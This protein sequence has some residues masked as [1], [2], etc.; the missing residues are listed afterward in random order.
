MFII[1]RALIFGQISLY[2][3]YQNICIHLDLLLLLLLSSPLLLLGPWVCTI[4][5]PLPT[6][7]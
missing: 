4:R 5:P 3:L 2:F 1:N 6:L 7:A